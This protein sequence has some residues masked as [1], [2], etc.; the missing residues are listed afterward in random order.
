MLIPGDD[1]REGRFPPSFSQNPQHK[2][3]HTRSRTVG[4]PKDYFDPAAAAAAVAR[5][6]SLDLL[7]PAM[8]DL[9]E[10]T[11]PLRPHSANAALFSPPLVENADIT[12]GRPSKQIED[13][14]HS[15]T[16]RMGGLDIDR[17][18]LDTSSDYDGDGPGLHDT[19]DETTDDENNNAPKKIRGRE[20]HRSFAE[21]SPEPRKYSTVALNAKPLLNVEPHN[22]DY[23]DTHEL[24]SIFDYKV[25]DFKDAD[26]PT[27]TARHVAINRSD[28]LHDLITPLPNQRLVRTKKRLMK[29]LI[30]K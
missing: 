23:H 7:Y 1:E 5:G 3:N 29:L 13:S 2:L 15:V 11:A 16:K 24:E 4:H 17:A 30:T 28:S 21:D 19:R 25:P 12:I 18:F 8:D 14:L 20:I 26:A 9:I 22:T 6:E 10:P 27:P